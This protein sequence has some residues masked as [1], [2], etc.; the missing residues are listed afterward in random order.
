MIKMQ[1]EFQELDADKILKMPAS[2][3]IEIC[4]ELDSIA[5]KNK[6]IN[7]QNAGDT[8]GT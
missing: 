2:R 6:G 4:K 8:F 3:F 1:I 7:R 5:N